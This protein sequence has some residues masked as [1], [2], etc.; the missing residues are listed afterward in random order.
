MLVIAADICYPVGIHFF[1]VK[2]G[3]TRIVSAICTKST[4]KTSERRQLLIYLIHC[5]VVFIVDF[6][7][8]N[9]GWESWQ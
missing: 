6:E 9:A 5:F 3:N 8:V 7:Q 1:K 4:I 2:S